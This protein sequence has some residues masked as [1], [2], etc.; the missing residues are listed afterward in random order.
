MPDVKSLASHLRDLKS[1]TLKKTKD[2]LAVDIAGNHIKILHGTEEAN[3]QIV[4]RT[5]RQKQFDEDAEDQIAQYLADY[6]QEARIVPLKVVCTLPSNLIIA[7]NVDMPSS[8]PNEIRKIVDLQAGRYTPYSRD[9]VVIDYLS[10]VNPGQHFTN[11][12]LIIVQ[13]KLVDRCLN[14]MQSVGVTLDRIVIA[15]EGMSRVYPQLAGIVHEG[16]VLGG[17]HIHGEAS[18]LTVMDHNRMVFVRSIP[19]GVNMLRAD[20]EGGTASFLTELQQSLAA[21]QDHGVGGAVTTLLMTGIVHELEFLREAVSKA[22]PPVQPTELD[23]R[24]M[25]Y[26]SIFAMDSVEYGSK[27]DTRESSF[28]ELAAAIHHGNEC[29]IDL[30][31]S[32]IQMKR[33]FR[34][35]GRDIITMGI[36]IMACLVMICSYLGSRVYLKQSLIDELDAAFEITSVQARSFESASTKAR[37][38]RNLIENR[39]KG[40]YVFDKVTSL[41]G[42]NVYL[43]HYSYDEEGNIT[44]RGTADSMSGV[45]GFVTKLEDSGY[46]S[47]VVTN[48]TQTRRVKGDDVADFSIECVLLEEI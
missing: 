10:M 11:V 7:K 38:L 2:L 12:L 36:L 40:I 27:E 19:V 1:I 23:V 37:L 17:V 18:E 24:M 26:E 44:L 41:V 45:F 48:E 20:R 14:I 5:A 25:P 30:V 46:F 39:G 6:F 3:K 43:T 34:K 35:S 16:E 13:R 22:N 9:E 28:F 31:P 15:S 29:A 47:S 42:T 21:Y 32:E 33:K 4:M 8:D